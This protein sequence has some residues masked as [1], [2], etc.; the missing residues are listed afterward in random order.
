M[1]GTIVNAIAIVAGSV[2]GSLLRK[3]LRPQWQ[4][5]MFTAIGLSAT[6]LGINAVCHHMPQ[7][8]SPVLFIVSMSLGGLIGTMLR[9]DDRLKGLLARF[10][11]QQ[12]SVAVAAQP[13]LAQGLCTGILLYCIGTLSI[14]GPINSA[15]L[16]DHTYLFTNAALDLVT[17]TILASTYS[18]GMVLC[19]PV[20]FLWQGLI[21]V[22][23]SALGST[24][25]PQLLTELSIVGGLLIASTGMSILGIKDC[26]TLNLLPALIIPVLYQL[27]C[28]LTAW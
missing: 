22:A 25:P 1:T 4:Q 8:Q 9:L 24:I 2:L 19:A 10:Q 18:L 7:S 16:S 28:A 17:S 14:L 11:K 6:A 5:V 3:Q 21:Y 12:E 27:L 26:K 13:P 23:A 20:L 15:L